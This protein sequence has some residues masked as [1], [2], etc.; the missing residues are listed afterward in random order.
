LLHGASPVGREAKSEKERNSSIDIPPWTATRQ[1]L[2]KMVDQ[3]MNSQ[4]SHIATSMTESLQFPVVNPGAQRYSLEWGTMLPRPRSFAFDRIKVPR[5]VTKFPVVEVLSCVP[6]QIN[7]Y[8]LLTEGVDAVSGSEWDTIAKSVFQLK[9]GLSDGDGAHAALDAFKNLL[10]ECSGEWVD[11]RLRIVE[12]AQSASSNASRRSDYCLTSL[13][14]IA[15]EA[16]REAAKHRSSPELSLVHRQVAH[17]LR[18]LGMS[19]VLVCQRLRTK[20]GQDIGVRW[21]LASWGPEW[22]TRA[23]RNDLAEIKTDLPMILATRHSKGIFDYAQV[24]PTYIPDILKTYDAPLSTGQICSVIVSRIS[25]PLVSNPGNPHPDHDIGSSQDP[26]ELAGLTRIP[27]PED[28]LIQKELQ[29]KFFSA[30]TEQEL[31]VFRMKEN[32]K[33]IGEIA[34]ELSCSKKT[35]NNVWRS[36]FQK[37]KE[38]LLQ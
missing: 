31:S 37:V 11:K 7:Y 24:L 9:E 35:V 27:S 6:G 20:K 12:K 38:L 22:R 4:E 36:I 33:T 5:A 21:G 34:E 15:A 32:E 14:T 17:H 13:R 3:P 16:A 29:A 23:P 28:V 25:P 2:R 18:Q 1:T 10:F 30:L 8:R 19:G 26:L